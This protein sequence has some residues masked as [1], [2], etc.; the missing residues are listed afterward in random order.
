MLRKR[1]DCT[2]SW[3][4]P[5]TGRQLLAL[6]VR[7]IDHR[8]KHSEGSNLMS[9][10]VLAPPPSLLLPFFLQKNLVALLVA[11]GYS[12]DLLRI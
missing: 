4:I 8:L 9:E 12:L 3:E 2:P 1:R 5:Q 7:S 11:P 10:I 6:N